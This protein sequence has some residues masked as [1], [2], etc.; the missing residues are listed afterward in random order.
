MDEAVF[1][2]LGLK[3]FD[4]QVEPARHLTKLLRSGQNA[5][6]GSDMGV[7][8]TPVAAAVIKELNL[9]TLV[10]APKISLTAWRR[11]GEAMGVEFDVTNAENV[12]TGKTPFGRWTNPKPK[13]P[14]TKLV[15]N[16]CQLTVTP[17][18]MCPHHPKGIHCVEVKRVPHDYG[19]FIWHPGVKLLVI[20]EAHRFCA[21]DSLNADMLVAA[22]VRGIRILALSA[23]IADSPLH[24]RALGAAIGLHRYTDFYSFAFKNGAKK[25]PFGGLYFAGDE[26]ER[27]Q[28]MANLHRQIFP[29]RGVR[30]CKKD[31]PNFPECQV[32]TEL[33][34]LTDT[35]KIDRLYAEMDDAVR[36][37]RESK[38]DAVL[39]ITRILR[40]R[41]ELELV[42]V[43]VFQEL[44]EQSLENGAHVVIFTNFK[45]TMDELAK[46]LKTNCRIEGGQ[47]EKVRQGNIDAFQDDLEPVCLA[48]S[49]AAGISITLSDVRGFFPRVGIVSLG[50]SAVK[51]RQV[52]GRLPRTVS[53]SK[54]IYRIPLIA[55]TVQEKIHRAVSAKQNQIDAL[56]DGDLAAGNLV[57]TPGD[58]STLSDCLCQ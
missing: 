38:S 6:D 43:P 56:N 46:R 51:T 16:A 55:G 25:H 45:P 8:K 52:L 37:L 36:A 58:L 35:K 29:S 3:L 12:R 54:S 30:V 9:P 24:L 39:E 26:S 7:G 48:N 13:E 50:Y 33:Y 42:M 57:L 18:L 44:T 23:T 21:M 4:Y 53:K 20:D 10:L 1:S 22:W 34:D 47:N 40:A 32:L 49:D 41:Q 19:K 31:L 15:C 27:L 11:V 5:I 2:Q 28:H 14:V 17:G